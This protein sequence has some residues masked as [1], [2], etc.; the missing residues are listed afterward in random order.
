MDEILASPNQN[1]EQWSTGDLQVDGGFDTVFV[2]FGHWTRIA[3][4]GLGAL[5]RCPHGIW[6]TAT[7]APDGSFDTMLL[8]RP[9]DS[10]RGG[11]IAHPT[12]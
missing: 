9:A 8:P 6:S 10:A 5:L 7:L 4:T 2:S 1:N 11:H 3:S 12:G